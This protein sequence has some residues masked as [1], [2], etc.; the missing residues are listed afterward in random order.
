MCE[1]GRTSSDDL[2]DGKTSMGEAMAKAIS[3]PS[4]KDHP[5]SLQ[6]RQFAAV[7]KLPGME[8]SGYIGKDPTVGELKELIRS[9]G[10]DI[11][12]GWGL[13]SGSEMMAAIKN[14]PAIYAFGQILNHAR[15]RAELYDRERLTPLNKKIK[16]LYNRDWKQAESLMAVMKK[17][18]FARTRFS[19][20]ELRLAGL[21]DSQIEVYTGFRNEFDVALKRINTSRAERNLKPVEPHEAYVAS[22]WGGDWKTPVYDKHG[23]V[24][25]Y[26]A[27]RSQAKAEHAVAWLAKN[28]PELDIGR[29]KVEYYKDQVHLKDGFSWINNYTKMKEILGE[30][31]PLLKELEEAYNQ[32]LETEGQGVLG[33]EKHFKAKTGVRGFLG[34]R[35]WANDK[36]DVSA[37]WEGQMSQLRN[38]HLEAELKG[39]SSKINEV[40]KDKDLAKDYENMFDLVKDVWRAEMGRGSHKAVV[41]LE[42]AL[43]KKLGQLGDYFPATD[44]QGLQRGMNMAKEWFYLSK[45]GF[46]NVPFAMVNVVQPVFTLP[47]HLELALDGYKFNPISAMFDTMH[48]TGAELARQMHNHLGGEHRSIDSMTTV[49]K[50]FR[51]AAKYMEA[52]GMLA[53]NQFS[54]I[55]QMEHSDAY[56]KAKKFL[57]LSI[58]APER[59]ARTTAFMSYVSHLDQSGRFGEDKLAMF[60]KAKELTDKSMVNYKHTA[61]ADVFNKLGVSG[62]ALATLQSFKINQFNQLYDF[63]KDAYK[64]MK[65]GDPKAMLPLMTLLGTQ[66]VMAGVMGLYAMDAVEDMWDYYKDAYVALG[67]DNTKILDFSPK[68]FMLEN[69]GPVMAMGAFSEVMGSNYQ[70]RQDAGVIMTPTVEGMLPFV[71]DFGKQGLEV[72]RALR[73]RNRESVDKAVAAVL[74]SSL[75]GFYEVHMSK[76]HTDTK[77]NPYT[78]DRKE[79]AYKRTPQE[80][81][82][83]GYPFHGVGSVKEAATKQEAFLSKNAQAYREKAASNIIEKFDTALRYQ[84]KAGMKEYLQKY[85]KLTQDPSAVEA[86]ESSGEGKLERR[87]LTTYQNMLERAAKAGVSDAELQRIK[88]RMESSKNV[89]E[90]Y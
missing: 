51:D 82:Q 83:R 36:D 67:G 11:T 41:A 18:M 9:G 22:R 10:E 29:S 62:S 5:I 60:D 8:M 33:M 35:P 7:S 38:S 30:D 23:R 90:N 12:K 58:T 1:V 80:T 57:G 81:A 84:D 88:R 59:V 27:E 31:S 63:G 78:N 28:R 13:I 20:E 72:A 69:M 21:T 53:L 43:S 6:D 77:G 66:M 65:A 55:G 86:L 49:S 61:R 74:P 87:R 68:K 14:H 42:T 17:E 44:I 85:A 39:A 15:A 16:T 45:L 54:E 76:T 46:F 48:V 75:K 71:G 2:T 3:N 32:K 52:N 40:M 19:E 73:D 79:L 70:S 34:D 56:T 25:W 47:H 26:I 89:R 4:N 50:T 64:G 24:V 37:F